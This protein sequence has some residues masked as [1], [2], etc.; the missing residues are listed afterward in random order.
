MRR[1]TRAPRDDV[2][3]SPVPSFSPLTASISWYSVIHTRGVEAWGLM[4]ALALRYSSTI[5]MLTAA[6]A[7]RFKL[8]L[9]CHKIFH[10]ALL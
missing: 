10:L 2:T 8:D 7:H 1:L 5:W 6:G 4:S 3:R 9:G